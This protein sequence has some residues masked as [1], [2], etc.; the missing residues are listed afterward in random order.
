MQAPLTDRLLRYWRSALGPEVRFQ[1]TPL[2]LSGGFDTAII[3]FRLIGAPDHLSGHL[4]LRLMSSETSP[5]RISREAATHLALI[6]RQF[7]VPRVIVAE[8][9]PAPL[10]GPFLIMERL[11]GSNMVQA[12]MER[13]GRLSHMIAMPRSLAKVQALLHSIP[14]NALHE[15]AQK[16]DL[17]PD[18][19]TI[20][21]EVDRLTRRAEH[22]RLAGLRAG[23]AWLARN[24]PSPAEPTVICHGDFHPLNVVM[25][26][27]TFSGVVDWAQA[28]VAEP[29]CD[30]AAT[31]V[32]L[33][34]S[35]L[36]EPSWARL[37]V[38]G[39]R[40]LGASR[41]TAAYRSARPFI[42]RNLP[43][44]EAMRIF[45]ALTVAGSAPPR[46]AGPWR[47]PRT[48]ERLLQRFEH[49]TGQRISLC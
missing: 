19:F 23:A 37:P 4:V 2:R 35:N 29:A 8:T 33:L 25:D 18:Y 5:Q 21:A 49:I 46:S 40:K 38:E 45:Q 6:D 17:E 1:T 9:D 13:T 30:V 11:V 31:R 41:Y 36:G 14:G 7:P 34:L 24:L 43:Y 48:L 42:D 15:A 28:I 47:A 10:G 32:V 12:A 22:A 44:F 3:A 16:F 27:E 39:L 26:G 20:A